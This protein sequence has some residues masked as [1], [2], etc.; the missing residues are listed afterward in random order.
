MYYLQYFLKFITILILCL[1]EKVVLFHLDIRNVLLLVY[2]ASTAW[3]YCVQYSDLVLR[4]VCNS[5][6]RLAHAA[7]QGWF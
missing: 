3:D 5:Q 2:R 4:A 7:S 1:K 6:N